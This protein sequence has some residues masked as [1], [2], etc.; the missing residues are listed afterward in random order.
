MRTDLIH[1]LQLH[2]ELLTV[3]DIPTLYEK[4]PPVLVTNE[5]EV[6][7][8][9]H[10]ME[11]N[12]SREYRWDLW[13]MYRDALRLA[14]ITK[15]QTKTSQTLISSWKKPAQTQTIEF[16][17]KIVQTKK[18]NYT[19]VP[20]LSNFIFGLRGRTDDSQHVIEL[21]RPIEE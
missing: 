19:N 7:T 1:F 5:V 16:K 2:G 17:D 10:P 6:Q 4:P 13:D 3:R 9:L 12:I 18:D 8:E 21:T 11:S 14:N 20:T 15:C